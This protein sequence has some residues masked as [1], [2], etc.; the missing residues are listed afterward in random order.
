M[1]D[2]S[3]EVI[4]EY[5][6]DVHASS[7]GSGFPTEK[8]LESSPNLFPTPDE[9]RRALVYAQSPWNLNNLPLY[10]KYVSDLIHV[11]SV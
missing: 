5:G 8:L 1:Q 10:G 4:V 9:R 11:I 2:Y 6:A 3:E 7:H